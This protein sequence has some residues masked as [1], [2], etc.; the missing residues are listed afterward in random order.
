ME[1]HPL[2]F[3]EASGI[4]PAVKQLQKT[5]TVCPVD[6]TTHNLGM[7]CK[8]Y[9]QY[10]ESK[11]ISS[12]TYSVVMNETLE[13]ILARHRKFNKKYKYI[14]VDKLPYQYAIRKFNKVP[15]GWRFIAGVCGEKRDK[16]KHSKEQTVLEIYKRPPHEAYCS[17]TDRIASNEG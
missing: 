9:Y 4:T 12:K 3:K 8:S 15:T 2:L 14:H 5:F 11:Q 13:E 7:V 16:T 17:T 6:K 10:V 1:A